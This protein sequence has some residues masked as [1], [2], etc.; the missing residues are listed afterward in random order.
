MG[1]EFKR[2]WIRIAGNSNRIKSATPPYW[3][4][5]IDGEDDTILLTGW[6]LVGEA[7]AGNN[8]QGTKPDAADEEFLAWVSYFG[9][10]SIDENRHATIVLLPAPVI[11]P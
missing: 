7:A 9:D 5:R 10:V 2:K 8:K 4:C 3:R 11:G 6:T 1:I